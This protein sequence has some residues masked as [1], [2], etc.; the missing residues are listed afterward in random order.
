MAVG[1][2]VAGI[3]GRIGK[4]DCVGLRSS[5]GVVLACHGS[6]GRGFVFEGFGWGSFGIGRRKVEIDGKA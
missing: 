4:V 2:V 6:C 3:V 1:V 5:A